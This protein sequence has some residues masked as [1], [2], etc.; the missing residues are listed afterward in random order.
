[1]VEGYVIIKAFDLNQGITF[2]TTT[3]KNLKGTVSAKSL[4][5]AD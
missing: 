1:M 4:R 2:K 3:K 5:Y